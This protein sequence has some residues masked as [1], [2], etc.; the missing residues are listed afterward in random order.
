[1]T[2][3]RKIQNNNKDVYYHN[4]IQHLRSKDAVFNHILGLG[5]SEGVLT[6]PELIAYLEN[7]NDGLSFDFVNMINAIHELDNQEAVVKL[8][9]KVV[10]V[11]YDLMVD[12]I[13]GRVF[14]SYANAV[15]WVIDN[16]G[17]LSE[18][19][20]W[21]IIL[22][23]GLIT[24]DVAKYKYIELEFMPG[25]ILETLKSN[26][27][28]QT[29]TDYFHAIV[30]NVYVKNI[31]LEEGRFLLIGNSI[32]QNIQC[33]ISGRL[34]ISSCIINGNCDFDN[35][36]T[37]LLYSFIGNN[38]NVVGFNNVSC[39]FSFINCPIVINSNQLNVV[40]C[41]VY[42]VQLEV[43]GVVYSANTHIHTFQNNGG[44]FNNYDKV[45]YSD[46]HGT[47][48]NVGCV[49]YVEGDGFSR[50]EMVMKTGVDVYEWVVV[51]EN[52]W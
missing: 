43:G 51:K 7:I 52:I 38:A 14:I 34:F 9:S 30:Q 17:V 37:D 32:I 2:K 35:I 1:M 46:I 24:E 48:D 3:I 19:N 28:F 36:E 12:N 22:P 50:Y 47:V 44:L 8:L 10:Y 42:N 4:L 41:F 26:V 21:T 33:T 31:I 45:L 18:T 25:C 29:G 39:H 27:N 15:Q 5:A 16:A 11:N 23:S 6:N 49:R 40:N 13:E 20:Q